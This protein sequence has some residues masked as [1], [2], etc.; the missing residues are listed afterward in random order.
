MNLTK[1]DIGVIL[2]IVLLLIAMVGGSLFIFNLL[3]KDRVENEQ[4]YLSRESQ[5][6]AEQI[7]RSFNQFR[8]DVE[9][10]FSNSENNFFGQSQLS[11]SELADIKSLMVEHRD[12]IKSMT[13]SSEG[14]SRRV[15]WYGKGTFEVQQIDTTLQ[16]EDSANQLKFING[17]NNAFLTTENGA[18]IFELKTNEFVNDQFRRY[19]SSLDSYKSLLD[20]SGVIA[21]DNPGGNRLF[22]TNNILETPL[23][24]AF[25]AE[26]ATSLEVDLKINENGEQ[27]SFVT[28][29]YP[30]NIYGESIGLVFAMPKSVVVDSIRQNLFFV[31]AVNLLVIVLVVFVFSRSIQQLRKS[32]QELRENRQNLEK[33]IDQQKLLFEYSR[34]FTY[35]HNADY[36]YDY[37]SENVQK[38]LGYTP[39][40]FEKSEYRLFTQNPLNRTAHET[41]SKVLQGVD[42]GNLFYAEVRDKNGNP[43]TLEVKEKPYKDD[44]GNVVGVIGIAKD[45]TDK[46]MSEQKFRILFE[47]SS[48]PHLI[49]NSDGI[50]DCNEAALQMLNISRKDDFIGKLPWEFSKDRQPD[51]RRS[52]YKAD[53]MLNAA[54]EKGKHTFDWTYRK[55]SGQEVPTEV[56]YTAVT[57]NNEQ[58]ILAVW[59]DLTERKR[60]EQA[61]IDAKQRAEEL[62]RSKQQFLSSMS[63]EI[64]TPLNA[65]IGYTSFLLEEDPKDDQID[66]L[67]SLKFSADN[68]LALV[69]DILDHSKIESGKIS[70]S[71]EP[72]QLKDIVSQVGEM[73]REKTDEKGVELAIE[74]DSRVPVKVLGDENRLNQIL[75]NIVGNA[76]KFTDEGKVEMRV[77]QISETRDHHEIEFKITDT[78]IG[79]PEDKKEAIF[80]AFEQA[81]SSILN[82]Y[83]GTGLGLSI[84]KNL[85]EMQGGS[86]KAESEQGKG[87]EFT[88][89][90]SFE[91]CLETEKIEDDSTGQQ[92]EGRKNQS[93]KDDLKGYHILLVEDN[94]INQK[95]AAQFLNKWG[96]KVTVSE[97]GKDA[98]DVITSKDFDLILMDLQMPEMDG[99]EA[100]KAIR[101][102]DEEY[103][104]N[105]P[106]V[107]L[108]ADAFNEVRDNVLEVGM[109]DYVTKPINPEEF[110][111]VMTRYL[112]EEAKT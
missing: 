77:S 101:S 85:V 81:D 86:I 99:Y 54:L 49:F 75:I 24:E 47:Y 13:I 22:T 2:T 55:T 33:L 63:H 58:V 65:V 108:T 48:D 82:T 9:F 105:I 96:A 41:T 7:E 20:A 57:L 103:F 87:S 45:V 73:M 53:E 66:K 98:L 106:V 68:L 25:E 40:E 67:K 71:N 26:V 6:C 91:K 94:P 107:A 80:N 60:V 37:V 93:G 52:E 36:E 3:L 69:N 18:V 28:A 46:F 8:Y 23:K 50:L 83:G 12:L 78:G 32:A 11:T 100:T 16:F 92:H 39:E 76:V 90:L 74:I 4:N 109:N 38:V 42:D 88:V 62:A 64:R 21:S 110:L 79:I 97:N 1:K 44:E 15:K 84:T 51:G 70:F 59:H 43:I 10:L 72:L 34:D 19:F 102:I 95:I 104:K 17:Y 112:K 61:L 5:I 35:R 111:K 31:I 14:G 27:E 56:T 89:I 30:V 29:F